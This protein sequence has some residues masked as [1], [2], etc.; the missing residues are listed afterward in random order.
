MTILKVTKIASIA[1]LMMNAG[2]CAAD[3]VKK[4]TWLPDANV[5]LSNSLD[6]PA[7]QGQSF[8]CFEQIFVRIDLE[9]Q[10]TES[11]YEH[12]D[13]VVEWI[14]PRDETQERTNIRTTYIKGQP[15]QS[16]A[17][18]KLNAGKGNS[19]FRFMDPSLG[20]E[21]FIGPWK[22]KVIMDGKRFAEKEFVV[23]C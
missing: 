23:E 22:A 7:Q 14:N 18:L 2:V 19:I 8:D 4:A 5:S 21:E 15:T 11:T 10:D 13:T 6:G 12:W 20:V 17:Y 9:D 3:S 1:L 16:H